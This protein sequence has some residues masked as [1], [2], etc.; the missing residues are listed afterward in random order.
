MLLDATDMSWFVV[1]KSA[2]ELRHWL[3]DVLLGG[4]FIWLVEIILC[5][6]DLI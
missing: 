1:R 4:E 3:K 6:L 2:I 5:C